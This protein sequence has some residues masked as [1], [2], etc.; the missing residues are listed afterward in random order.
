MAIDESNVKKI[1]KL[2]KIKLSP[3][4]VSSYAN[5]FEKILQYVDKLEELDTEE[6][7]PLSH[8]HDLTNV[9]RKDEAESID[10]RKQFLENAPGKKGPYFQVPRVIED[11]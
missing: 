8:V 6:I 7:E 2:A 5:Q 10:N 3:D 9:L 4:E 1:A 11:E